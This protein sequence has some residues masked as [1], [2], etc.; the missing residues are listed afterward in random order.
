MRMTFFFF[1]QLLIRLHRAIKH[2]RGDIIEI[3]LLTIN[4]W[5]QDLQIHWN[6][7]DPEWHQSKWKWRWTA[8][9]CWL[10]PTTLK[11]C[12]LWILASVH[13][14]ENV[15]Y[16]TRKNLF[17]DPHLSFCHTHLNAVSSC[18]AV[19]HSLVH[20]SVLCITIFKQSFCQ[21]SPVVFCSAWLKVVDTNFILSARASQ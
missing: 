1:C 3:T 14:G 10:Y 16:F 21:S 13:L 17:R 4:H 2:G 12:C 5:C 15:W 6:P 11:C 7:C 8:R 18:S 19:P 9:F 20:N